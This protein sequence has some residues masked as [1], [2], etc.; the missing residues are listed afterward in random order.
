MNAVRS[1]VALVVGAVVAAGLTVAG[2]PPATAAVPAGFTDS[3]VASVPNPSAIAFTADGRMLVTQQSGR[4]RVRTA[5]GVLLETPALDLA[6][7]SCANSE[8][9]LLGVA[10][11]P[12]PATRAIYL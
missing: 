6:S 4:L 12:D 9:G 2:S 3:L 10:T 5:A 1:L 7:R 11:D 8:R